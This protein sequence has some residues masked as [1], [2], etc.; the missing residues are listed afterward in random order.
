MR[1]QFGPVPTPVP[2]VRGGL[3]VREPD[4]PPEAGWKTPML[5]G[6]GAVRTIP[7]G[8]SQFG[9]IASC[10]DELSFMLFEL[11]CICG[12]CAWKG[13]P[14]VWISSAGV[15]M[16]CREVCS[17]ATN[18]ERCS[19]G[20]TNLCV[21][22]DECE[23]SDC[24]QRRTQFLSV[25]ER[26]LNFLAAHPEIIAEAFDRLSGVT[27]KDRTAIASCVASKLAAGVTVDVKPMEGKNGF[28]PF[29][30][31]GVVTQGPI[32][33]DCGEGSVL[34]RYLD[35]G[36][37][38]LFLCVAGIILHELAHACGVSHGISYPDDP[39]M[40]GL[41]GNDHNFVGLLI[42]QRLQTEFVT[43]AGGNNRAC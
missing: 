3:L 26:A 13:E 23:N 30:Q 18:L 27:Q 41:F 2:W 16:V 6:P 4:G 5:R 40:E 29:Y 31:E 11:P 24:E 9:G 15:R 28:T 10:A 36:G 21:K 14:Y 20:T 32:F 19:C 25:A 37:R 38:D 17:W 33:L 42:P 1:A 43:A 35:V 39:F 22:M 8:F 7:W 34:R 12:N